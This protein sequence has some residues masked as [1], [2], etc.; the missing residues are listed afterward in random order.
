MEKY[1]KFDDASKGINPFTPVAPSDKLEGVKNILRIVL[2]VF[3]VLLRVPCILLGVWLG[4]TLHCW[5][6]I[7]MVPALIRYAERFVDGL[8]TKLLMGTASYNNIKEKYHRE[9]E[10][11]NFI[12]E[13]RGELVVEHVESDVIICNSSCFVDYI[14]LAQMYSPCFTRIVYVEL[15]NGESKVGLRILGPIESIFSALGLS[16]PETVTVESPSIYYSIK[17]LR[18]ADGFLCYKG[19]RPV[20]IMPEGTK[21]NGNGVLKIDKDVVKMI[22]KAG[23]LDEN[24]R[25]TA[26]RFEH[27]FAYLSPYNTTDYWGFSNFINVVTQFTSKLTIQYYFNL[28]GVLLDCQSDKDKHDFIQRTLMFRN[29][30][31]SL[32]LTWRDH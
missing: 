5:K 10:K 2:K 11:F 1:R 32:S 3:F 23:S 27:T 21:T 25:I 20:V 9:H 7:L 17:E 8:Y 15:P 13:Q 14:W 19:R 6:Y 18:E 31:E 26:M 29:K 28:E 30:E 24:L 4:M 12:K 16:F 22:E